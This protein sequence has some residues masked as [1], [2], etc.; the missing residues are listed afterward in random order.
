MWE[1]YLEK[2]QNNICLIKRLDTFINAMFYFILT[3]FHTADTEDIKNMNKIQV[4][5]QQRIY[6]F[7]FNILFMKADYFEEFQYKIFLLFPP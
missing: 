6:T 2:K 7:S 1:I 5:M 4:I 3:T